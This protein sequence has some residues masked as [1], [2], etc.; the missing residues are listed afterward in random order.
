MWHQPAGREAHRPS[1]N[2]HKCFRFSAN[3]TSFI[4][5]TTGTS[6]LIFFRLVFDRLAC[7]GHFLETN[8]VL[9]STLSI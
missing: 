5:K 1:S 9:D 3:A 6:S 7:Q 8:P 4:L 2:G